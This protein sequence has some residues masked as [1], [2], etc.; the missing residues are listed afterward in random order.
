MASINGVFIIIFFYQMLSAYRVFD[1]RILKTGNILIIYNL[2]TFNVQFYS[3]V[4]YLVCNIAALI[5][6]KYDMMKTVKF[7]VAV[8]VSLCFADVNAYTE[9][10]ILQNKTSKEELRTLVVTDQKWVTFPDYENRNGW[11]KLFGESKKTI[12]EKGEKCL[13]Y[14]WQVVKATDYLEFERTGN[15]QIMEKPFGDNNQAIMQLL[16]AELAEGKGR[17]IDQLING[18][19]HTCEMTSWALSAHLITQPSHRALPDS[20][21]QLID[22]TAGDLG[23]LLSWT[24]YFMHDEFDKIDPEISKR[25]YRELDKRIMTPYLEN[26]NFWWLAWNYKGQM[27]NNWNPWCNSNALMTFMLL[28][29]N[30]DRLSDAVYRSMISVDRFLNYVHSDGACEEGPSYW[31]H[32]SG[33]ALDYLVLLEY[34]TNGKISVFDNSQIKSMGEY[35]AKSYVG[36][37]WVVNF[38]DASAKG[39]GDPYL[40]YRYG[41]AVDSDEL[42]QFASMLNSKNGI[43]FTGR[44]VFR[45]LEAL[46]ISDELANYTEEYKSSNFT[47]YPETEFCYLR[48]DKAFFAAKGGYNDESHNHND[49]GTFSLWVNNTPVIIDA[50]VGTYTKQTFSSERYNIWTM[51]SNYHNLPMINGVPQ[52]YGRKFKANDAKASKNSFSVEI[53]SAYPDEAAVESWVRSYKFSKNSLTISD[54]FRLSESKSPN[55]INFM[56]WGDVDI[57]N[58]GIVFIT[59]DGVKAKLDYDSDLFEIKKE[60][61]EISDKRLSDVWGNKIYRLS[62]TSKANN[63]T[64]HYSFKIGF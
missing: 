15:R 52:K 19:F 8:I 10:N 62:F 13:D 54:D 5:R 25:L 12:I 56:T 58:D 51:Q 38:A 16:L 44:D 43:S 57:Q 9:R 45:I 42:K 11:D 47:W 41:K 32:A 22:L 37:G 27:V 1:K 40:I 49:A 24:Y 61:V 23:G 34:I 35:I 60:T 33:K 55:V 20:Q 48:N 2:C 64:G 17:F 30:P 53:A 21:Y 14:E 31:G 46:R 50:G 7:F 18:V 63:L 3:L 26:N 29:D 39:G 4:M 36:N 59:I 28:E 6:N